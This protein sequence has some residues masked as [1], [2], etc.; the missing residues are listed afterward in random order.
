MME[1]SVLFIAY[2]H[3]QQTIRRIS[4]THHAKPLTIEQLCLAGAVSGGVV[5][6]VLTPVELVKCQ[7][8]VS[9]SASG[10]FK[11]PFSLLSH[12]IKTRGFFGLYRGHWGTLMREVAG[13]AA[14]F[15]VYEYSVKQMLLDKPGL[16]KEQLSPVQLMGA[17]ALAGMSYNAGIYNL[18]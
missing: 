14:W 18:I 11:G 6:F 10:R 17:G 15:G 2:N 5:S 4:G 7:L 16:T 8:Q 3:I 12:T 13:G 1:N 9:E